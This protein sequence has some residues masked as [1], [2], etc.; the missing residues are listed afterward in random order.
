MSLILYPDTPLRGR[1]TGVTV[2]CVRS[3]LLTPPVAG[4]MDAG[5]SPFDAASPCDEDTAHPPHQK[6]SP[7]PRVL[8]SI[9][10]EV[11]ELGGRAMLIGA[12]LGVT[13]ELELIA[14]H[15]GLVDQIYHVVPVV[16]ELDAIQQPVKAICQATLTEGSI[17]LIRLRLTETAPDLLA[18]LSPGSERIAS[19]PLRKK[20]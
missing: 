15:P 8:A 7:G 5:L 6:R 16:P 3:I 2:A 1:T 20:P 17:H 12:E 11:S 9:P 19:R 10:V 4:S 18:L 13:A 14:D